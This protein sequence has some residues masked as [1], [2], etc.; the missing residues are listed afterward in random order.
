[1]EREREGGGGF[2]F[3]GVLG[4]GRMREK[5]RANMQNKTQKKKFKNKKKYI[6]IADL[7]V[8]AAALPPLHTDATERLRRVR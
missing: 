4:A 3:D 7:S 1:M 8:S 2:Y 6:V 5:Q